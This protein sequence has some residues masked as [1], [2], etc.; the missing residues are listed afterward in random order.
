M[1]FAIVYFKADFVF[2]F[3]FLLLCISQNKLRRQAWILYEYH[4]VLSTPLSCRRRA[5]LCVVSRGRGKKTLFLGE[6]PM[7]IIIIGF[8][9]FSYKLL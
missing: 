2:D 4:N 6:K 7:K 5:A 8:A 9:F 1:K 3:C